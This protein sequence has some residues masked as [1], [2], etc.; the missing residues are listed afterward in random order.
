MTREQLQAEKETLIQ[1]IRFYN[2][3]TPERE[4]KVKRIEELERL[5]G[6]A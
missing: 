2:V 5:L 1:H 4:E 6:D 3:K